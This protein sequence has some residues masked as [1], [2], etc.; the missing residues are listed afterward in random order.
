MRRQSFTCLIPLIF[1]SFLGTLMSTA[2]LRAQDSEDVGSAECRAVQLEAQD[3]VLAD[4]PLLNHG[5]EASWARVSPRLVRAL[6]LARLMTAARVVVRANKLGDISGSC[7]GCI[8]SQ[9]ARRIPIEDQRTCGSD[10]P[11]DIED[12]ELVPCPCWNA[13]ALDLDPTTLE[14]K[15][16]ILVEGLSG[17][18]GFR[19]DGAFWLALTCDGGRCPTPQCE[20]VDEA[21]AVYTTLLEITEEEYKSC[22]ASFLESAMLA[23]NCP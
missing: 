23:Y 9:F 3:A 18:S 7:A 10:D 14:R 19:P 13:E 1:G 11:G 4:A 5:S 16:C 15:A 17:I 12:P 8:I 2:T 22:Q 6:R 21:N 20:F